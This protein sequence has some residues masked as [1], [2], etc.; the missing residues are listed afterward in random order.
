MRNPK[1]KTGKNINAALDGRRR[2]VIESV[3]PQVDGGRYPIK[4][5]VGEKITVAADVFADGH[6]TLSCVLRYRPTNE[7]EWQEAPMQPLVNDQW[8]GAFMVAQVG[9][10][11]YTVSAW[12]DTFKSWR[13]ELSR[14]VELADIAVALRVGVELLE[15]ASKHAEDGDAQW[16]K[17][18]ARVLDSEQDIGYRLHLALAEDLA[19]LM[20]R[21]SDRQLAATYDQELAVVVEDERARFSSWYELFPRSYGLTPGQHGTFLD[22]M[23]QLP[24]IADMGFDVLYFPPIHPIGRI[25]RKGKNNTMTPTEDDVGS[26]WAIGSE[27]GGHKAIHP[28]LGTLED[29]R[30]LVAKAKD[31]GIEI[32]LDIAFQCAPDHPYVKE[33][34]S[35]F[36]WRPDGTVQYA[37]NPPKKYQDIYPFNF[38]TD[39]WK[40]LWQ[41]LKSIFDY[42]IEQGIR[43]FRVDN[44]HTKPFPMWEWIITEIKKDHPEAMFLAEAFTRPKV[45]HRLAKLGYTQSYTY[46]TWRNTKWELTEYM[47]ELTQGPGREY[48]RPN[49][50]PNTPDILP[51]S[52]QY[53]GRSGYLVRLILAATM[54]ANY[55]MYGPAFELMVSDPLKHGGEDYLDSEKYEIKQWG[56]LLERQ[57]SLRETIGLVNRIRRRNPALQQNLNFCFHPISNEQLICYS[58]WNDDQSDIVLVIVNLDTRHTQAG[59][60]D[61]DLEVLGLD[62]QRAFEVHDLLGDER[63][64]WHGARNYVELNPQLMPAHILRLHGRTRTERDFDYFLG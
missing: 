7:A 31:Y 38:E 58:K 21:Y 18:R 29:F 2:V 12:V 37:E 55:G 44:P 13:H 6:D 20:E 47:K 11:H 4:R 3:T 1:Q 26:P 19:A 5:T 46:F 24:R 40:A 35:W 57:D 39:D 17:S 23:T 14:R 43:I 59:W 9:R 16:L 10:Y 41:E 49:F 52:L 51:E 27:E 25:N 30:A 63:Y 45:M 53:G 15:K 28:A 36:R 60:V 62:P 8:E 56:D 34:P 33:H 22:V 61:L 32:A 50:W 42:W 54:T 48:F 64:L